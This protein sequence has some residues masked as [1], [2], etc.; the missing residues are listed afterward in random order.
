MAAAGAYKDTANTSATPFLAEEVLLEY[1]EEL[2][3]MN[4]RLNEFLV[5]YA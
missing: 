1:A 5:A 2:E 4:A 3:K